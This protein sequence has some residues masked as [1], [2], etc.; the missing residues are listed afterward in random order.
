MFLNKKFVLLLIFLL[1][2]LISVKIYTPYLIYKY[3]SYKLNHLDT[4]DL[5]ETYTNENV[6][7]SFRYLANGEV[8]KWSKTDENSLRVFSEKTINRSNKGAVCDIYV[9]DPKR[10][11]SSDETDTVKFDGIGWKKWKIID[12][13]GSTLDRHNVNWYTTNGDNTF[14][15]TS[16]IESEGYCE[17][18]VS[19]FKFI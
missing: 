3:Q 2:L 12:N 16:I 14:F 1:L 10:I 7:Y 15:I 13:T 6:G 11:A 18:I 19:S 8:F 9:N 5:S 4:N 17:S